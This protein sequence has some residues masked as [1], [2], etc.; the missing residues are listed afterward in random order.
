LVDWG[1]VASQI[2]AHMERSKTTGASR[3]SRTTV[4]TFRRLLRD[5][6]APALAGRERD[7]GPAAELIS[8]VEAVVAGEIFLVPLSRLDPPGGRRRRFN[9]RR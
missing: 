7:L 5:V 8:S 2:V 6:L 1:A 9:V 3:S 4:E